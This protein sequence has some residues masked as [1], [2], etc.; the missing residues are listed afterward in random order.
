MWG[1]FLGRCLGTHKYSRSPYQGGNRYID[2]LS[3]RTRTDLHDDR[4]WR[5]RVARYVYRDDEQTPTGAQAPQQLAMGSVRSQQSQFGSVRSQQPTTAPPTR[6]NS[7]REALLPSGRR[8]VNQEEPFEKQADNCVESSFEDYAKDE[9]W[10]CCDK[11]RS[12]TW[13]L[14]V[15]CGHLFCTDCSDAMMKRRMPCPLCRQVSTVVRRGPKKPT[16]A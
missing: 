9:C 1:G 13:D 2:M 10:V 5:A 6:T 15:Q 3:F 11:G 7:L 14:W 8:V 16:E 12:G 4:D